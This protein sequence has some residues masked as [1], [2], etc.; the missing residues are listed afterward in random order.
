[1]IEGQKLSFLKTEMTSPDWIKNRLKSYDPKIAAER[2]SAIDLIYL[3][4]D[5]ERGRI[6]EFTPETLA[7]CLWI[8]AA[9]SDNALLSKFSIEMRDI[10]QNNIEKMSDDLIEDASKALGISVEYQ[11]RRIFRVSALDFIQFNSRLSG[12][13]YRLAFQNLSSGWITMD[14]VSLAKLMRECFVQRLG[15]FYS[16][17][18]REDALDAMRDLMEMID[19]VSESW[20][21]IKG[22][23]VSELGPVNQML[24]PPCIKEYLVE[25]RDGVNLPHMARF[26]LTSFLHK[27]GMKNEDIMALFRTAPDFNERLTEY[28]VNHV[29]G[30][31]SGTEYSPPKCEVLRSNH[32]CYW[33]EDKLCHQEWL[34]HPLQYYM[35]K[36][37]KR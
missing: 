37:R 34:R 1:M 32:L 21:N 16:H 33:G 24:F 13:K 27:I 29:T 2:S 3:I 31:S 4:I 26:T 14:K 17:L 20:K 18:N 10:Y 23:R 11:E 35:I 30:Q 8:I 25:M 5:D 7:I 22:R 19:Y 12:I 28:Q 15:T 9:I 36:N 6:E